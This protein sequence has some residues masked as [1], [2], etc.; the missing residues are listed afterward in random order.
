M[1]GYE[2]ESRRNILALQDGGIDTNP[3]SHWYTPEQPELLQLHANIEYRGWREEY[4][5]P[6]VTKV[7]RYIIALE[8]GNREEIVDAWIRNEPAG[9]PLEEVIQS[10]NLLSDRVVNAVEG[11]EDSYSPF[12]LLAPLLS[13]QL[14]EDVDPSFTPYNVVAPFTPEL[15]FGGYDRFV[16]FVQAMYQRMGIPFEVDH[17]IPKFSDFYPAGEEPHDQREVDERDIVFVRQLRH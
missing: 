9:R 7:Y 14:P 1:A 5:D 11:W 10:T 16:A 2:K 3:T 4:I 12:Q 6:E 13:Y 8:V 17:E 15:G